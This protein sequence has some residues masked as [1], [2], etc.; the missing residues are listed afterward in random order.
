MERYRA[1]KA[2]LFEL[3]GR[4]PKP[5]RAAVINLDDP[6][7]RQLLSDASGLGLDDWSFGRN[8]AARVRIAAESEHS[9]GVDLVLRHRDAAGDVVIRAPLVGAH[10]VENMA[11]AVAACAALGY[12]LDE[13]ANVIPRIPQVPGR[14]ER[15]G[16]APVRVFVDYAH[17]PDALERAL[18]AVRVST[19][20]KLWVVF[21]CGGDRDRGKRP[22]MARIAEQGAD[23]VV[24][25]SD[26]PRTEPALSIID[27][28]VAGCS[29]KPIVEPDRRAA[30]TSALRTCEEGDTVL[31][32][33]KGHEDYQILGT[34][35]VYFS[36]RDVA[37]GV[38]TERF[39]TT[40]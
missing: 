40:S 32:A 14:L 7:G 27:E 28:I 13:V 11:A 10:N 6:A 23:R 35:K 31:I 2:R 21:G 37:A 39:D 38:L 18:S 12:P 19:T 33:G 29:S 4:S 8:S 5:T 20:G 25:T 24:V 17:T 30:I 16:S 36:D 3:V 26:N 9:G 15:V 22:V 1:A 34:E